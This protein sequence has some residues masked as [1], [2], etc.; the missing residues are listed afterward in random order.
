M[1]RRLNKVAIVGAGLIG[2]AFAVTFARAGWTAALWDP[3]EGVSNAARTWCGEAL[4]DLA[5]HGLVDDTPAD[6]LSRIAIAPTLATALDGAQH[7]QESG[8]EDRD[9]KAKT[10]ADLDRLA[11][12]DAILASS[13]SAIL[14]SLFTEGLAGR[15]R[16]LVAH[17]VNPPHLVP[18]IEICGAPWTAPET[19]ERARQTF[20][21]IG[22]APILVRHEVDGFILNR[23]QAALLTEAFRLL[24]DGA[25]S[26]H[27]LDLVM[28]EGLGLRWS[29]MGPLQTIS[30]NAPE[31]IAD[32]CARYSG[33]FR[34]LL[35]DPPDASVWSPEATKAVAEAFGPAR[36]P[37]A[38]ENTSA[39]RDD[40]L[41]ALAAHK[42][43]QGGPPN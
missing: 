16:T 12:D 42:R 38:Q 19:L 43:S 40:R 13:T 35:A 3:G 10:F 7:V 28:S 32:Y 18:V 6:V 24:R 9:V 37:P 20:L 5:R 33:F 41:A 22:Q 25:V 36:A 4:D 26:P 8:P 30:L 21:D 14:P 39:W 1:D 15:H 29:F 31:G 23:L 2:R 34:R 17:P 27:D 11:A